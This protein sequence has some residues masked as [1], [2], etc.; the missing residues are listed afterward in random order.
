MSVIPFAKPEK[1]EQDVS[2]PHGAGEAFCLE[3][4]HVW[5]AVSPIGE[6]RFECPA[7][8][9]MKGMWTFEFDPPEDHAWACNC[10]NQL[11]NITPDGTF[12]PKC[13]TY[14]KF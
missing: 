14:Q 2:E 11:F 7:C 9:S 3:C 12:C 1:P 10:G 8:H 13:G 6:T 5:A 4:D